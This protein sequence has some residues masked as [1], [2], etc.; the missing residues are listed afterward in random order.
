MELEKSLSN[1]KITASCYIKHY[2]ERYKQQTQTLKNYEVNKFSK[3]TNAIRFNLL[4]VC[5]SKLPFVFAVLFILSMN[6]LFLLNDRDRAP[7]SARKSSK[8][9]IKFSF[10]GT[11]KLSE[12]VVSL[13]NEI[14][15]LN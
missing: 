11:T 13:A 5:P 4:Q 10:R 8:K 9:P 2:I 12:R 14:I 7:L 1:D 6:I 15:D 3:I